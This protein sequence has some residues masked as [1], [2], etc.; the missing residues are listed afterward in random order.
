MRLTM[1][2]HW[3]PFEHFGAQPW[4]RLFSGQATPSEVRCCSGMFAL[5]PLA[6]AAMVH[7]PIA[8]ESLRFVVIFA[9]ILLLGSVWLKFV[10]AKVSWVL[11]TIF[12][13]VE[14]WL[15]LSGRI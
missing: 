4:V 2:F 10:P 13:L 3:F 7:L 6:I 1:W 8:A 11:G 14:V 12:W 9:G 5:M 15:A